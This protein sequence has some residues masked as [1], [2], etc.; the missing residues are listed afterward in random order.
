GVLARWV[1]APA[2]VLILTT[3]LQIDP[4]FINL[5]GHFSGSRWFLPREQANF[6]LEDLILAAAL[7]AYVIGHFRLT[8]IVHQGM[9][10]DPTPRREGDPKTPPPPPPQPAPPPAFPP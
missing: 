10:N 3:Y 9:P 2:L 6:Q 5:I 4:G 8:T 1:V 7:L